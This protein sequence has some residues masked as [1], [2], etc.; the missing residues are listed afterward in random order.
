MYCIGFKIQ[1][2]FLTIS[3]VHNIIIFR[4]KTKQNYLKKLYSYD[5]KHELK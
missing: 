4:E 1:S 3:T 2:K 5:G